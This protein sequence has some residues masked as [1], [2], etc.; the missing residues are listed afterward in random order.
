M[1][2]MIPLCHFLQ[3][4]ANTIRHCFRFMGMYMVFGGFIEPIFLSFLRGQYYDALFLAHITGL[5]AGFWMFTWVML[6]LF[7]IRRLWRL[8]LTEKWHEEQKRLSQRGFA[9]QTT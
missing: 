9:F 8:T 4:G 2:M 3:I 5:P 6:A 1:V 7:A